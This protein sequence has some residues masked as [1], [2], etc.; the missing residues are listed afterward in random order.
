MKGI[1][2]ITLL[3]IS[4]GVQTSVEPSKSNDVGIVGNWIITS[5]K[6]LST[7]QFE[8]FSQDGYGSFYMLLGT[9]WRESN[10][11]VFNLQEDGQ[12]K[13]NVVDSDFISQIDMRYKIVNDS[14]I[15][16]SCK[17]PKDTIRNIMPVKYEIDGKVMRWLLDDFLEIKLKKD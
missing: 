2:Y 7:P 1:I 5:N 16:F 12:V 6:A 8:N 10:N 17:L 9:H 3:L 4:C 11:K 14:L 15:D 13:T